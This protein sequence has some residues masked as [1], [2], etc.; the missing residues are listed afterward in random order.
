MSMT[1]EL[2]DELSK[3]A[4]SPAS[5]RR[6]QLAAVLRLC[7]ELRMSR[8]GLVVAAEVPTAAVARYLRREI[9]ALHGVRAVAT[10]M[11]RSAA[12]HGG[13][14]LVRVSAEDGGG[15]LAR[16]AGLIDERGRPVSG[17][18]TAVVG[19][20]PGEVAAAWRGAFLASG[21]LTGRSQSPAMEIKCPSTEAAYALAS[22]ARRLGV[23]SLVREARGVDRVIV[24]DAEDIA[25]LLTRIGALTA[26]MQWERRNARRGMIRRANLDKANACRSTRAAANTAARVERALS[27]LG[28]DAPEHLADTGTLRITHRHASLEELGRLADPPLTKD[29]VAGR[30]RRLLALADKQAEAGEPQ[31]PLLAAAK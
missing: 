23:A 9:A 8:G 5:C 16:A 22:C 25:A 28:D 29:S 19:G 15:V 17:L 18:P 20:S 11:A 14:Y 1:S 10:V 7:G 2:R 31:V 21:S 27:L 26:R 12:V 30:L 3:V 4:A 13:R 24:R 6:A